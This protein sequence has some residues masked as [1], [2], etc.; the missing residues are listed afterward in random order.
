MTEQ[1]KIASAK[2]SAI[3]AEIKQIIR[4]NKSFKLSPENQRKINLLIAEAQK[5]AKDNPKLAF[6]GIL[7]MTLNFLKGSKLGFYKVIG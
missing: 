5:L 7:N 1:Q 2:F 3:I 6:A 4:E